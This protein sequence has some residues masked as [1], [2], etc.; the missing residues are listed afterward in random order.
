[1]QR[2]V[3]LGVL[4]ALSSP[5]HAQDVPPSSSGE[6]LLIRAV[7]DDVSPK[8]AQWLA[9]NA[10]PVGL[11]PDEYLDLPKRTAEAVASALCGRSTAT[12]WTVFREEN[13][14]AAPLDPTATLGAKAYD[15]RW[16]ACFYVEKGRFSHVVQ[17]DE[18]AA[19]VYERQT[20][21]RG[22]NR[23]YEHFFAGSGIRRLSAIDPGD[24]LRFSFRTRAVAVIPRGDPASF[25]ADLA[26]IAS[27]DVG[28]AE[29]M[30]TTVAAP[31]ALIEGEIVLDA[32]EE[33]AIAGTAIPPI[34]CVARGGVPFDVARASAAFGFRPHER[35]DAIHVVLIDNGFFG[36]TR[37]AG[38]I[39]FAPRFEK[40]FFRISTDRDGNQT[41]GPRLSWEP[42]KTV[43]PFNRENGFPPGMAPDA[44]SGHGTHIAGLLAGSLGSGDEVLFNPSSQPSWLQLSVVAFSPGKRTISNY[45]VPQFDVALRQIRLMNAHVVNMSV[46]FGSGVSE[47]LRTLV[48][49]RPE[50]LFVVAAGNEGADLNKPN[51]RTYPA[52]LGSDQPNV[53]T[54]GAEDGA[55]NLSAFSNRGADVVDLVAP[56]CNLPSS[57]DGESQTPLSGT[58]QATPVVSLAAA[59]LA[60][61]GYGAEQIKRRLV[62]SGDLIEGLLAKAAGAVSTTLVTADTPVP[63]RSRSRLNFAKAQYAKFDYLRY[64]DASGSRVEVVGRLGVR[65]GPSCGRPERSFQD[66]VAFKRLASDQSGWCFWRNRLEPDAVATPVSARLDFEIEAVLDAQGSPQPATGALSELA[67]AQVEEFVMSVERAD[68]ATQ[69]E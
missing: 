64:R 54:I 1:M 27:E 17:K 19:R 53:I 58:S 18:S 7:R 36:A 35:P 59:L 24:V 6:V 8:V 60:R 5:T 65:S 30:L 25:T 16:P 14:L 39:A 56:G 45:T 21:S 22:K 44:E 57:L 26:S 28:L 50:T 69:G 3:T 49:G 67:L 52:M 29:N 61:Q 11:A 41:I 47:Q 23:S 55:G 42:G 32:H 20:G 9:K 12:Y 4:V 33:G 10:Q 40:R 2:A 66:V 15:Y 68:L 46:R 37:S 48:K 62:Q 51:A 63:I 38:Q 34:D 43:S 13:K 31:P